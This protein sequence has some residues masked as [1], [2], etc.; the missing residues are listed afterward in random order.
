MQPTVKLHFMQQ[1]GEFFQA[2]GHAA[3]LNLFVCA[4]EPIIAGTLRYFEMK[5]NPETLAP[6]D[7]GEKLPCSS[8]STPLCHRRARWQAIAQSHLTLKY[9]SIFPFDVCC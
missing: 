5:R 8:T 6:F 3:K 1:T 9:F 7:E 2:H 4:G